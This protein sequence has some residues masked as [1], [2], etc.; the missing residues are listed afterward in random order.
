[1]ESTRPLRDK[2]NKFFKLT[3]ISNEKIHKA[4]KYF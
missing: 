2:C 3:K 4:A 1:M